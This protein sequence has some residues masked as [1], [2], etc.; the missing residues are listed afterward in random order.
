MKGCEIMK[1][2]E[3]PKIKKL[4]NTGKQESL[5]SVLTHKGWDEWNTRKSRVTTAPF[6]GI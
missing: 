3:R 1:K 4:R 6:M 2:L 5:R